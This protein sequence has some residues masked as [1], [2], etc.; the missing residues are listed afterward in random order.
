M[1]VICISTPDYV[2]DGARL[3]T[4]LSYATATYGLDANEHLA[5]SLGS[6]SALNVSNL[7]NTNLTAKKIAAINSAVDQAV[8]DHTSEDENGKPVY[9]PDIAQAAIDA[10][11]QGL[12][13]A[14]ALDPD[15]P[16]D[17]DK[18]VDPDDPVVTPDDGILG[19]LQGLKSNLEAWIK[20]IPDSITSGVNTIKSVLET[21]WTTLWGHLTGIGDTLETIANSLVSGFSQVVEGVTDIPG[22]L[23]G[24]FTNLHEWILDIPAVLE[25]GFASLQE[26]ILDIPVSISDAADLIQGILAEGIQAIPDADSITAPIVDAVTDAFTVDPDVVQE[27]I[28]AESTSLW[29]LPFL[30]DAKEIFDAL[31]FPDMY[32]YPKIKIAT[33]E[34]IKPYY[35]QPEIVLLDFEDYKD[36]CLWARLLFRA[37]IWLALVWHVVDLA[38][39]RLRIS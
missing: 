37:A 14:G 32:H 12:Q 19:F 6:F 31:K 11:N 22:T 33:P 28:A 35:D 23:E 18:P 4:V 34:I 10:Y 25:G 17:P 27:V 13:D 16:V 38:T 8:A 9:T 7:A 1:P 5:T 15:V 30:A 2:P 24:L 36:Y 26:W 21:G 39:P 20:A 29:E 3:S